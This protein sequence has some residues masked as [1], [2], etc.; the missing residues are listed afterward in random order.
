MRF[1]WVL[2][3]LFTAAWAKTNPDDYPLTAHVN[4]AV[5]THTTETNSYV[6]EVSIAD[7]IYVLDRICKAAKPGEDYPAQLDNRKLHLLVGD[8]VC[9]YRVNGI[10]DAQAQVR[11]Q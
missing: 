7:K 8:K 11:P 5:F 6:T 9:R 10:K 1:A 3:F 4:S 2:L